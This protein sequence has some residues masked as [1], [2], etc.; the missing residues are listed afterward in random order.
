[1]LK[2]K[3]AIGLLA[4]L[5]AMQAIADTRVNVVGLFS[6]KALVTINGGSPQSLSAGQ[7][8]NGVK[9]VSAD[10]NSATFI[11]EGKRQVL[12]MGQAVAVARSATAAADGSAGGTNS[13]VSLYADSAGHFY[14][15]LSING[16]SLK[17]VVDTGATAV[18]I[19]SGDAKYAKID[20]EK[21][22]QV[23]VSTANGEVPAYLVTLNTLKIGTIIL[24]NV[25]AV[26]TEGGSPPIVL[27]GMSAQ[28]RL[29]IKRENSIMT[30][31]KKY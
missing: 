26:V 4:S 14:G 9:L 31:S 7:T 12:K 29:D 17:Y 23:T 20:Y 28:N 24:N 10:S 2:I 18:A 5:L 30:L 15:N 3:S 19:N 6:N 16:A 22:Q 21:G 27:L 11:I 25:Q 8:N 13:P 1:M